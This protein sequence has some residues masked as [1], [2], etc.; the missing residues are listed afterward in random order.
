MSY[1]SPR[2]ASR[3]AL[4]ACAAFSLAACQDATA[5]TL[6]SRSAGPTEPASLQPI[7]FAA[8]RT[9]VQFDFH[10]G[11][12]YSFSCGAFEGRAVGS[13]DAHGTLFFNRQG[14]EA[15]LKVHI[16][17]RLTVTNLSTGATIEDNADYNDHLDLTTQVMA[18][19]GKYFSI[20]VK[21]GPVIRDIGRF[22]FD[23]DTREV[24]FEAGPHDV[25]LEPLEPF[26]CQALS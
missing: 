3:V 6:Q 13:V 7:A 26:Y 5:P 20:K 1:P 2:T 15:R 19:T 16:E 14:D 11:V 23:R 18:T 22:V 10:E 17:P 24:L 25:G 12:E 4:L 9:P 8:A 21:G